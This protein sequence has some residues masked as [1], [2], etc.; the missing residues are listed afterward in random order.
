MCPPR[1]EERSMY[2]GIS[3]GTQQAWESDRFELKTLIHL[4]IIVK[5]Y[6]LTS[7]SRFPSTSEKRGSSYQPTKRVEGAGRVSCCLARSRHNTPGM[8]TRVTGSP[9]EGEN[10]GSGISSNS[11]P[12]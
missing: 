11:E 8:G 7:E 1:I 2:L 10:V 9:F 12:W 6:L 5:A 3:L 4:L